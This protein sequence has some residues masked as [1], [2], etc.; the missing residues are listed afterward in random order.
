MNEAQV[1]HQ[2]LHLQAYMLNREEI[3]KI[4]IKISPSTLPQTPENA[5][6]GHEPLDYYLRMVRHLHN[7]FSGGGLYD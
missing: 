5:A 7:M 1:F 2:S 4:Q 3:E 6:W